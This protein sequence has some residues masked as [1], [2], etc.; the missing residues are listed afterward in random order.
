LTLSLLSAFGEE[1]LDVTDASMAINY[2]LNRVRFPAP[3][4]VGCRV[5]ATATIDKVSVADIHVEVLLGFV[6]ESDMASKPVCVAE[7]VSRFYTAQ[8]NTLSM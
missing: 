2:G 1:L 7:S 3:A 6:L 4:P 5:R 8:S